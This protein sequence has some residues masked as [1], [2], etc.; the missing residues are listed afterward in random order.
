MR[1]QIIKFFHWL[2]AFIEIPVPPSE[3]IGNILAFFDASVDEGT[4]VGDGPGN[5]AEKRLN[6]L[7]NMI[8]A[9]SDLIEVGLF[10]EA[11]QQLLDVYRR[12]DGQPSPPDFV[13]GE[14][15]PELAAMIQELMTSLGCE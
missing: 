12:M 9:A 2:I 10:E 3:Q 7:R 14:A 4:I 8:E 15:V 13:K 6:A 5:S 1:K 11:C